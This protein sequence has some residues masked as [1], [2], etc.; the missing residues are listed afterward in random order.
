MKAVLALALLLTCSSCGQF[1]R[2]ADGTLDRI[3]TERTFK[4]GLIAPLPERGGSNEV[5]RFLAQ[6]ADATSARPDIS[7]GDTEP[8]LKL[9]EDGKLD[10]VI[11]HF[12]KKSPWATMVEIGPALR[13]EKQGKA[14]IQLAPVMPIGENAWV[15]L[16]EAKARN[17]G[18]QT[19]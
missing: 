19:K 3:R 14:E 1:P 9:L 18:E 17:V 12:D 16:I 11:G 2:D 15:A 8:L 7:T 10:L 6:V 13:I 5:Q 4:V